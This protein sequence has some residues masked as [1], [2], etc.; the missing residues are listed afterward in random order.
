MS[1]SASKQGQTPKNL[2]GTPASQDNAMK[3]TGSALSKG[4]EAKPKMDAA[5]TKAKASVW[6]GCT[7][8]PQAL[9]ANLGFENGLPNIVSDANL[10]RSLTPKDTPESSK[11]SGSSEPNSDISEGA[12]LEIDMN[13]QTIDTDLLL[14][15]NNASL[16]GDFTSLDP[17]LLLDPP[18]RPAPDWDDV[19]VDF[20]KPFELDLSMYSLDT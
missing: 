15:L 7:I 12:A 14:D 13:W 10:Y 20:T 4:V 9:L 19:D 1:V 11:D 5:G 8:D 6:A 18:S 17:M 2:A 3:R 16:G